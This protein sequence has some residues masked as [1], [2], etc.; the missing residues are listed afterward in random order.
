MRGSNDQKAM[1]GSDG[2]VGRRTAPNLIYC[3]NRVGKNNAQSNFFESMAEWEEILLWCQLIVPIV[4]WEEILLRNQF[5]VL[6]GEWEN[7]C[8]EI[9]SCCN[10]G[11]GKN[12]APKSI[13]IPIAEWG[14]IIAS[15]SFYCSGLGVEKNAPKSILYSIAE[16]EKQFFEINLLFWSRSGKTN[17]RSI[18]VPIAEWEEILLRSYFIVSIAE[19]E[20]LLLRSQ[21]I[22]ANA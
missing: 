3:S 1:Y 5:I 21:L 10:R 19:W 15:K 16:R 17:E 22:V 4:D 20:E 12:T 11:V 13:S 6:T 8:S 2:G 14:K 7:Y 9:I 18:F